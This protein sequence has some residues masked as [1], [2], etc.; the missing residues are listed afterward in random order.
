LR[1][2]W[3]NRFLN[4]GTRWTRTDFALVEGVEDQPFDRLIEEV[5]VG[6][7]DVGEEDVPTST[8]VA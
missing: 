7:H 2:A 3:V 5:V 6:V 4:Q 8:D 1:I